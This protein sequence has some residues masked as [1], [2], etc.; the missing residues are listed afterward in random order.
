MTL[1]KALYAFTLFTALALPVRAGVKYY[2]NDFL[3]NGGDARS[4]A[5]GSAMAA[6]L[7]GRTAGLY[8]PAGLLGVRVITGQLTHASLF[9]GQLM[10]DMAAVVW[11]MDSSRSL[12][13]T[14][15]RSAVDEIWNTNNFETDA[16]GRPIFSRSRLTYSD[17]ADY[18]LGLTYAMRFGE[19]F[20][21]GATANFIRR[22]FD[23]LISFGAGLDAGAL[24]LFQNNITLGLSVRN[25]TTSVNRY[26]ADDYEIG[27]PELYLGAGYRMDVE[28]L[29]GSVLFLCQFPNLLPTSGVSQGPMAG[30]F[31][32]SDESPQAWD[33]ASAGPL[34]FV[35]NTGLGLEYTIRERVALRLGTNSV[36]TVTAGVGILLKRLTVDF[37]YR[38]HPELSDSYR[39][40]LAWD[41][42]RN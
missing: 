27:L 14:L 5:L 10:Q 26:Y 41:F 28:Y 29:Y 30:A 24:F 6:D 3:N 34:G 2:V 7:A 8:N 9:N 20:R 42:L 19:R 1:I 22:R 32:N 39:F 36:S 13:A 21:A 11:P 33:L 15:M 35:A 18:A 4:V 12:G 37:A 17:N 31:D 16:E 40:A 25:L 38:S 23:D